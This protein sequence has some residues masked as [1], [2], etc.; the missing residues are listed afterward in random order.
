MWAAE[1]KLK[2]GRSQG[3]KKKNPVGEYGHHQIR[4]SLGR[5]WLPG[6]ITDFIYLGEKRETKKLL[7]DWRSAPASQLDTLSTSLLGGKTFF[8]FQYNIKPHIWKTT[9][10]SLTLVFGF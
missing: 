4:Y 1:E 6:S 3:L 5:P 10:R 8:F 7:S 2:M 9:E